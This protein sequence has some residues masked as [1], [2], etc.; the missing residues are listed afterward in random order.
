MRSCGKGGRNAEALCGDLAA[1]IGDQDDDGVGVG[2]V[3]FEG[4]VEVDSF[5]FVGV[6]LDEFGGGGDGEGVDEVVGGFIGWGGELEDEGQTRD[7][8]DLI[9][10]MGTK[11]RVGLPEGGGREMGVGGVE[12]FGGASVEG[13]EDWFDGAEIGGGVE[14]VESRDKVGPGGQDARLDGGRG[15]DG[16]GLWGAGEKE[17]GG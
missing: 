8:L 2:G 17:A 14:R 15:A 1:A 11:E 6:P 7:I 3:G 5:G 13:E 12:F 9:E 4:E 10:E 16:L